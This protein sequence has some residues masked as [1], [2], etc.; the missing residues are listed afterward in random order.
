[1]LKTKEK[2]NEANPKRQYQIIVPFDKKKQ[3][4]Q[5]AEGICYNCYIIKKR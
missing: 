4:K 1:M 3:A 2:V 5:V